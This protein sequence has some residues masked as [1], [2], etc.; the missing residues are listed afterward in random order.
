MSGLSINCPLPIFPILS[1]S[2]MPSSLRCPTKSMYTSLIPNRNNWG[3][4]GNL[5][6]KF[7]KQIGKD[8][9]LPIFEVLTQH[10]CLGVKSTHLLSVEDI[11]T[12]ADLFDENLQNRWGDLNFQ[13]DAFLGTFLFLS[14][15]FSYETEDFEI[16]SGH[17]MNIEGILRGLGLPIASKISRELLANFKNGTEILQKRLTYLFPNVS[18]YEEACV[19][20]LAS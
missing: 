16:Y 7:K 11:S 17:D 9:I 1:T 4:F 8:H 2:L 18:S 13:R 12:F 5:K 19:N 15:I 20:H 10:A 14:R 6:K 3:D